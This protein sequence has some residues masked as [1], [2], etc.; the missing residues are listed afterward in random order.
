[1]TNKPFGLVVRAIIKDSDNNILILKRAPDSRSN[2][3]CWE[4][5]G[6]KVE[7]GESFDNAMIREITEETNLDISL[8]RA[9]GIAQQ[10]LPHIHSVHVIMTVEVNSGDL[11]ISAEHTEFKWAILEEIKSLNLSNWFESFLEEKDI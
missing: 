8:N 4:L 6:G 10:D 5:P 2:P 7:S 11:K 3:C 9:V 1:M